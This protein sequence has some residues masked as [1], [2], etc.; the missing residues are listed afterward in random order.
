MKKKILVGILSLGLLVILLTGCTKAKTPASNDA[1][2]IP[3]VASPTASLPSSAPF[4]PGSSSESPS[5]FIPNVFLLKV[6]EPVDAAVINQDTVIVKGQTAPGATVS[7]N[8]E[9]G[10]ADGSGNFSITVDLDEGIDA[11]DV[12]AIN[13]NGDAAEVLLLVTVDLSDTASAP[14]P[15]DSLRTLAN[16]GPGSISLKIISPVDG[17]DIDGDVVTVKGQTAPGAVVNVNDETDIADD[18]GVFSI[19]I[20]L[21]M[22]LNAIDVFA[23]DE[24]G[25]QAEELILVNAG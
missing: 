12:I 11:I 21:E 13:E 9:V 2:V 10:K 6:T 18:S 15:S 20:S 7:V 4:S 1:R 22:G 24:D 19:T 17:A 8:E 16:E 3:P 14:S 5:G 23:T 25:D